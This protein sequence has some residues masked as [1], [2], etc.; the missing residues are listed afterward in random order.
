[1]PEG[2]QLVE[3]E[4]ILVSARIYEELK[5]Y[6]AAEKAYRA[7]ANRDI[8]YRV[9][10]AGYLARRGKL[11]ESFRICDT[12]FSKETAAEICMNSLS[13]AVQHVDDLTPDQNRQIEQWIK[14]ARREVANPVNLL[15]QQ[16]ALLSAQG[17]YQKAL[18][19]LDSISTASLN[20]NQRGL[21]ANNRA[22]MNV[23]L[24]KAEESLEEINTAIDL[25]GPR[26]EVLD[27][28]A[29]IHLS[30]GDHQKAIEDLKEATLF[31]VKSGVYFFHL[32][33][34]YQTADNRPAAME[35]LKLA[36]DM[37]FLGDDVAPNEREQ[38]D[39]LR[40][41]LRH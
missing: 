40:R 15:I 28:R 3:P 4:K 30:R 11:D 26:V 5:M 37:Q 39:K 13:A 19:L 33:L 1:V 22:Y 9:A 10:L 35:A 23:R 29:M 2:N 24:G 17:E 21:L 14:R 8:Q 34:A 6:P 25:W 36:K 41:W 18:D 38:L 16:A 12:L 32:A 20:D 31:P 7:L 27:T